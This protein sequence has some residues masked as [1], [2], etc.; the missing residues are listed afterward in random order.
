MSKRI[1][2]RNVLKSM[3]LTIPMYIIWVHAYFAVKKE[4]AIAWNKM[5]DSIDESAITYDEDLDDCE[6]IDG[7]CD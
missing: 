5:M 2:P 1:K 7:F 3:L 6:S 4:N